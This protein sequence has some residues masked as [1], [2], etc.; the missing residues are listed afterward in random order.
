M[1]TRALTISSRTL[2]VFLAAALLLTYLF[3][4]YRGHVSAYPQFTKSYVRLDDLVALDTGVSGRVCFVPQATT[5]IK[6]IQ[7]TFPHTNGSTDYTLNTTAS[8]WTLDT[9]NLNT[10]SPLNEAAITSLP[11]TATSV[12]G[13]SME[14]DISS[15]FT[16]ANTNTNYCFNWSGSNTLQVPSA[17]A[18]EITP[19]SITTYSATGAVGS[20]TINT[21]EFSL[22]QTVATTGYNVSLSATVPPIFT[23]A[24]NTTSDTFGNLSITSATTSSG[25]QASVSTNASSGWILWVKDNAPSGACSSKGGLY[26]ATKNYCIKSAAS[27]NTNEHALTGAEHYDTSVTGVNAGTSGTCS[28]VAYQAGSGFAFDGITQSPN[29]GGVLSDTNYLP[30]ASCNG[31]AT[32]STV[33]FSE[34]ATILGSTP[35]AADYGDTIFL[36]GAGQF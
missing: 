17:G 13:L 12:S 19:G 6:S 1:K 29:W 24:L 34:I 25:V 33:N 14:L 10:G 16:P 31:T 11:A 27:I 2:Y 21:T 30:L 8:N 32:A 3:F 15:G 23:M 9:N 20:N 18:S 4:M 22:P 5:T 35:A 28:A 7:V 36:T 26:S